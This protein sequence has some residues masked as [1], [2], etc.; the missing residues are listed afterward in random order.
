MGKTEQIKKLEN[1][2]RWLIRESAHPKIMKSK[3]NDTAKTISAIHYAKKDI[4]NLWK[5]YNTERFNLGKISLS[6]PDVTNAYICGFHLSNAYRLYA[7]LSR[8]PLD[9]SASKINIIDIGSGSGALSH[10]LTHY[11]SNSQVQIKSI[12]AVK[13]LIDIQRK[14][15]VDLL[16]IED[17]YP[18]KTN[19]SQLRTD[20]LLSSDAKNF[21]LFGYVWNE[22]SANPA[23]KKRIYE[24]LR[25]AKEHDTTCI[26]L[27]PAKQKE[28]HSLI[29]LRQELIA[30]D[31][32][33]IYPCTR[34][35]QC[36]MSEAKHDWC[37]SEFSWNVPEEIAL[38]RKFLGI[39]YNKLNAAAFVFTS[40]KNMKRVGNVIVGNP[41]QKNSKKVDYLLCNEDGLSKQVIKKQ[42]RQLKGEIHSGDAG[43]K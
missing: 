42:P 37:Y 6:R 15:F 4:V 32:S 7:T 38:I 19:I 40:D 2:W 10:G 27:E 16:K 33:C 28:S 1:D 22:L 29:E 9:N 14:L 25:L 39:Q 13:S 23:A 24:L 17:F 18:I 21:I 5:T 41:N 3:N 8:M 31:Y 34:V 30:S 36:P 12:E 35:A 20:R 43:S 11:F 26:F